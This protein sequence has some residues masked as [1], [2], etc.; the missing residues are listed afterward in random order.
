M[1]ATEIFQK[2]LTAVSAET[3]I[4]PQ[5]ILS[6]NK[7]T[8]VVD[9]RFILIHL[10]LRQ[11]FSAARIAR[12]TGRTSRMVSYVNNHFDTRLRQS[13]YMRSILETVGKHIESNPD[14][15]RK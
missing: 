13:R 3:E 14:T 15:A 2:I 11:G 4:E 5:V 6:E 8:D 12:L 9:A 7:E 1:P 10:L